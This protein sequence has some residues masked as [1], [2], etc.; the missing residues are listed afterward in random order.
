MIVIENGAV[1]TVDAVGTEH[2][3]GHVVVDED[4]IV[5]V[6]SGPAPALPGPVRRVDAS[7]CLVTPGLVN[8]HHHLYQWATRGLAQQRD[9]FGW[10]TELYPIW[11]GIDEDVVGATAAAGLGW[12]AL[13]GCSTSTDHH[14]VFPRGRGDL[15]AATIDAAAAVGVRFDPVRGS[16]DLGVVRGWFAT[17]RSGGEDGRSPRRNAGR[18]RQIPQPGVRVNGAGRGRAMLALLRHHGPDARSR[19]AGTRRRRTTSHPPRRDLGR[20]LVLPARARLHPGRARGAARF[21]W[22]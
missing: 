2:R 10:L 22:R 20:V 14:Y 5:A 11:A 6:G 13:S 1:A 17:G 4:R 21:P 8:T 3:F 18:H 9:L 16:M 19:S 12:L 7:G 15:F